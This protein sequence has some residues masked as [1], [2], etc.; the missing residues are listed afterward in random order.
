M[1][2]CSLRQQNELI[3]WPPV[4]RETGLLG[5]W[6]GVGLVVANMIGAGVFLSTGFMAQD[7]GP[8]AILAAWLVGGTV[9]LAGAKAY[10]AVSAAIPRS[11]G[12]YRFLSEL[13]H[14]AVGY[15]AGWTSLLVGFS[16]PVAVDAVAAGSFA[17]TLWIGFDARWVGAGLVAVLTLLHV[18]RLK[19][20]RWTQ[21]SLVLLKGSLVAGFVAVGLIAGSRA[22]PTWQP[23]HPSK[24]FPLAPFIQ[25]LFYIAFAFSGWNAAAYVAEDF[26][27]PRKT[28]PRAMLI[29]CAMVAV[30]YLLVNW[31]FVANLTPE[32]ASAVFTYESK[33]ITLGHLILKHLLGELGGKLM[34]LMA[35]ALL[36]SATSAMIFAG[37]RIYAA[38]ARD[39]FLPRILG[40]TED[41]PPIGS[42]I[43]QSVLSIG[44]IF[45]HPVQQVLQNVGAVL[46]LSAALTSLCLFR[47]RFGRA[48]LPRPSFAALAAAS[49]YVLAAAWM[50][51]FGF[52]S[53]PL[54]LAWILVIVLF[55]L[56]AY[57]FTT[58]PHQSMLQ[59][60]RRKPG[61]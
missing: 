42:I 49:I 29:G 58:G 6:S 7:M 35:I 21:D 8:G 56:A 11:G 10:A 34:S 52:R 30:L 47:L 23:V 48:D 36:L 53:S 26:K 25:S 15:V 50:L 45:T 1:A 17:Q 22:W 60:E 24:G 4:R 18:V 5:L 28:V 43:L 51:Y 39:G 2:A 19:W 31:V 38:M 37:P 61:S 44:L 59:R 57:R 54:L 33:R 12:E 40:G 9:A 55:A 41:H 20:S 14:P 32:Q 3:T 46:T 16:A 27:E 13:L